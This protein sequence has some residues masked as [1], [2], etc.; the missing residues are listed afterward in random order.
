MKELLNPYPK[1]C[2]LHDPQAGTV[3]EPTSMHATAEP[4]DGGLSLHLTFAMMSAKAGPTET[5]FSQFFCATDAQ[6]AFD[7]WVRNQRLQLVSADE[8]KRL[9]SHY[10]ALWRAKP[11]E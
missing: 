7:M 1:P 11:T 2:F 6:V 8:C 3:Y 10:G 4:A 9:W 5:T